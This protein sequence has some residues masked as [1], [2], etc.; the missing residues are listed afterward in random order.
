MARARG[1][2]RGT[3]K[4]RPRFSPVDLSRYFDFPTPGRVP[5]AWRQRAARMPRGRETCWGIPFRFA[6]A[7]RRAHVVHLAQG[8]APVEIP[9]RGKATHV[10]VVHYWQGPA[11]EAF[12]YAGGEH[13]AEYTLRFAGDRE[14][15]LPIRT[16]FDINWGGE[17]WGQGLYCAVGRGMVGVRNFDTQEARRSPDCA[18][19]QIDVYEPGPSDPCLVALEN[20]HPQGRLMALVARG[21]HVTPVGIVGLTLYEG[22]GHPLRHSPR[23][24]FHL[25]VGNA[26]AEITSAE[27][28]LGIVVRQPVAVEQRGHQWL[29]H[30]DRGLGRPPEQRK[31]MGEAIVEVSAA[32]GATLTVTARTGRRRKQV[33]LSLGEAL[34]E[35]RSAAGKATLEVVHPRRTWVQVTVRDESTGDPTAVRIH[36]SGPRGEYYAPYG[37]HQ[38]VNTNWFE[39][40]GADVQLGGTPYA[41]VRG[42]FQTELPVGEVY[43]E[44]VKG[45]EYEPVRRKIRIRPGQRELELTIRRAHDWRTDGWVTADTHVHFISPHTAWLQGQGEGV[46]LI[47]LLASQWGR[48]FTNVGDITG[49]PSVEKDDTL[50][51]VGTENRNHMLGHLSM[52]GTQ[53]KPVY[54]MCCGGPHEAYVGDPD[55]RAMAEWADECRRKDGVVI[56]PHFPFPN[57]ENPVD[58]VLGKYDGVEFRGIGA[59]P[60]GPLEDPCLHEWYR[61]LNCGYR[62]AAVGGTD[63]MSAGMPVGGARTYARLDRNRGFNFAN[64]ARA[65]RKGRTFTTSGPLMELTVDGRAPGDVIRLKGGAGTVEMHAAASCVWPIHRLEIVVNGQVVATEHQREG[66]HRLELRHRM[67]LAGSCWI[68]ARCGSRLFQQH[69]WPTRVGAHTSPVYVVVPGSE[70]FSPSD[71]QYMLTMIEG[72]L[73]YLD[74]L[75][76]RADEKRHREIRRIYRQAHD[77]LHRRMVAHSH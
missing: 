60:G 47:N 17:G 8:K 5:R 23:R 72:G 57:L 28:D 34:R 43:V 75:S 33:A 35:G 52:L 64:W 36:F 58:I 24:Y 48:L 73:A 10:C 51:W 68:A 2:S 66:A 12:G 42:Q 41:Y 31:A 77:Q 46:N 50:V 21:M 4:Y 71:A 65:I 59:D 9:L 27:A 74:T 1:G 63:K 20:P 38:V 53:G 13:V 19:V 7:R 37:H 18:R 29:K 11:G 45:F 16:R 70:L 69:C 54:P 6:S 32:D 61:Y 15:V 39:D 56:R 62:V 26:K 49:E 55:L 25:D 40:Y 67:S 76:V 44:M 14:V 3:G 22:P 30:A